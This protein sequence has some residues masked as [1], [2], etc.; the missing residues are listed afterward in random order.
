MKKI[1][2]LLFLCFPFISFAQH[3]EY[4]DSLRNQMQFE[5][6]ITYIEGLEE[7]SEAFLLKKAEA[8]Y[9]LGNI[10]EAIKCLEEH[11]EDSENI[12]VYKKLANYYIKTKNEK[13]ALEVFQKSLR[14]TR[15]P[16]IYSEIAK[17]QYNLRKYEDSKQ[18]CDT[19]L[20][21]DTIPAIL[22]LQ[23]S[24][25]IALDKSREAEML[26]KRA[27]ERN[28]TDYLSVLTL[29]NLYKREGRYKDMLTMTE[30][31][32]EKDGDNVAVLSLN[33]Y[34]NFMLKKYDKAKIC[35]E[36]LIENGVNTGDVYFYLG[37]SCYRLKDYEEAYNYL[38]EAN[39]L[40]QEL[41]EVILYYLGLVAMEVNK[42][43]AGI[44]FLDKALTFYLPNKEMLQNLYNSQ[45][46]A[47]A[48]LG[49]YNQ[50]V[51]KTKRAMSY[52]YTYDLQYNLAYYYDM[53]EKISLAQKAYKKFLRNA[54]NNNEDRRLELMRKNAI[55]RI[56]ILKDEAFMKK[57]DTV[58][59]RKESG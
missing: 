10:A 51:Q 38:S 30:S 40:A 57:E 12:V 28:S 24:C 44:A 52:G 56:K 41:N 37:L 9:E 35:Y 5:K 19:L 3:R 13:N 49:K 39:I 31:Y 18:T 8:L 55:Y 43:E 20:I 29:G 47:F 46:R 48:E 34:A 7:K 22:R 33:G 16:I 50:S 36:S 54:T 17:L 26:L 58:S 15:A 11:L 23:S 59:L 21:K 2:T 53:Q 25:F 1:W 4:I 32:I 27:I 6:I 42:V 14:F 45:A